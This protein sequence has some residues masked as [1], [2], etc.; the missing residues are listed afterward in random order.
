MYLCF[1]IED[2]NSGRT[3]LIKYILFNQAIDED[4]VY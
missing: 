3:E 2:I 4:E 1:S